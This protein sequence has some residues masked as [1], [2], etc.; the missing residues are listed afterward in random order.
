MGFV[1]KVSHDSFP[2]QS[3]DLHKKTKV[4][5]NYDTSKK[6]NGTIVRDDKEYPFHTMIR[7]ADGRVVLA[8]ECQY[9]VPK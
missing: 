3:D 7:L 1:Q 9:S 5:F 6:I 8:S 2:M 4:C